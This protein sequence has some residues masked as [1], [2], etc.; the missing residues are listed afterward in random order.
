MLL[1]STSTPSA[2]H[3]ANVFIRRQTELVTENGSLLLDAQNMDIVEWTLAH[4]PL[5][6]TTTGN[7]EMTRNHNR[8]ET[9][10][11]T[12]EVSCRLPTRHHLYYQQNKTYFRTVNNI[13][14]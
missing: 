4:I 5:H 1:Y 6:R 13:L 12:V 7:L 9:E 10:T 8:S 14:S 2:T 3:I 11:R